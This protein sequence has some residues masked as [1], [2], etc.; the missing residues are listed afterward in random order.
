MRRVVLVLAM[1]I[2]FVIGTTFPT[3]GIGLTQATLGCD[4]GTTS[5]LVVDADTLI[6]LTQAVQAMIDYPAGLTCTLVQNPLGALFGG[7]ALA[8][9]GQSPFIVGGG[10]WELPCGLFPPPGGG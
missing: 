5:T 3:S 7:I 10:R 9:P 6:G 1:T 8:S 2:G 4:D